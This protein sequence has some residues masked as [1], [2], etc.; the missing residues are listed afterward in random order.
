MMKR[1]CIEAL[2]ITLRDVRGNNELFGGAVVMLAGDFRQTAPIVKRGGPAQ[3]LAASI[4]KSKLWPKCEVLAL[5]QNMRACGSGDDADAYRQWLL[6]VGDGRI[7][8]KVKIPAS[9]IYRPRCDVSKGRSRSEEV[10][11]ELAHS[12]FGECIRQPAQVGNGNP[13]APYAMGRRILGGL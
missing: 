8:P 1:F 5:N 2:D 3:V 9:M 13:V 6:G 12:V 4:L 10:V 7:G 11:Q